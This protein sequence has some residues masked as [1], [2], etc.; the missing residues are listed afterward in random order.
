MDMRFGTWNI[1]SLYRV[2]SL[3]TVWREL[4]RCRLD[5]V[6]VQEVIWEGSGTTPGG[7]YTFFYV[8]WNENHELDTGL[9]VHNRII[10]VVKRV[11]FVNDK[12]SYIILRSRWFHIIVLNVHAPTEDKIN[13]VKDSFYEELECIFDKFPKYHMKI[14]LEDLNAKVGREDIFKPT[15]ENE[16]LHEISNDNGVKVVNFTTSKN[17]IL[18]SKYRKYRKQIIWKCVTVQ[19]FGNDSNTSKFHS[20]GN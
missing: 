8:K 5:L 9:F 18:K 2:G 4:S 19:V 13:D 10:S 16:S 12:V 14:L 3:M 6:G 17:L 20:G 7:E 11:E 1:R 15:I